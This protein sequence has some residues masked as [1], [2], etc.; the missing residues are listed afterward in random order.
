MIR[1]F[2]F[3][4]M[5]TALVEAASYSVPAI[6]AILSEAEPLSYG[7]IYEVDG[8]DFGERIDNQKTYTLQQKIEDLFCL[9]ESEYSKVAIKC[10]EK[11]KKFSMEEVLSSYITTFENS[12]DFNYKNVRRAVI[13]Y[14]VL[15]SLAKLRK[16]FGFA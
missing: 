5:G 15:K 4:G 3:V 6:V 12:K 14:I 10:R 9:S 1:A 13:Y 2:C 8:Y 7:Y 11:A 16:M